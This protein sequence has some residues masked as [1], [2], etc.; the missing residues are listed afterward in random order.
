MFI[1]HLPSK[2]L[3]DKKFGCIFCCHSA[4]GNKLPVLF[5]EQQYLGHIY[6]VHMGQGRW[7]DKNVM[8]RVG[9]IISKTWPEQDQWD[10]LLLDLPA[11][12][13]AESEAGK[14]SL[15]SFSRQA[16]T[17]SGPDAGQVDL[18]APAPPELDREETDR[19]ELDDTAV[20]TPTSSS[21]SIPPVLPSIGYG[22]KPTANSSSGASLIE[23]VAEGEDEDSE[24]PLQYKFSE[25]NG[26]TK[27]NSSATI[28]RAPS[29]AF[30]S[31]YHAWIAGAIAGPSTAV[32]ATASITQ[33]MAHMAM[34]P[35]DF[36]D[37]K[38]PLVEP[39]TRRTT[40]YLSLQ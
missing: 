11:D 1:C 7:P 12:S 34:E 22:N 10:L 26:M 27:G 18:T 21:S 38:E 33:G 25:E 3:H 6:D 30:D 14:Q 37:D 17:T 28:Q 32:N 36:H 31:G 13:T 29:S 15:D 24:W 20:L 35:G 40:A 5:G 39:V 19:F 9:A 4:G 16:S 8:D 23:E 2:G